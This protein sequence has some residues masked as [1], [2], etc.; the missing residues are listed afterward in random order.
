MSGP[1]PFALDTRDVLDDTPAW[2]GPSG[3]V[4]A[5]RAPGAD[6]PPVLT[7]AWLEEPPGPGL[8][9]VMLEELARSDPDSVVIDYQAV[10]VNGVPAVRTLTVHREGGGVLLA[11]EQWRLLAAG[12]RWTISASTG[13]LDQA[14]YGPGLAAVAETFRVIA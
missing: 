2:V 6:P 13:L 12:C 10:R 8:D 14:A 5:T 3:A 11:S 9:D 1:L 7:V 4:F